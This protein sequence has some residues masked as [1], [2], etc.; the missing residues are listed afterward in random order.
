MNHS[1]G[2]RRRF[3]S[4]AGSAMIE[5]ALGWFIMTTVF[6]STFQY[7]YI[8][9]RYNT[10]LNAVNNG[11]HF[12]ALQNYDSA[13][14]TP[15]PA[16]IT[17]VQD[18]VAYGDPTGTSTTPLVQGLTPSHVTV[19]IGANGSGNTFTP[20]SV[21]VAIGGASNDYTINAVVA[22]FTLSGKPTVTYPFQGL[23]CPSGTGC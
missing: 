12:A 23:Y 16:F 9:Y 8:F 20:A 10:V 6:V 4:R 17:A 5:F 15:A 14:S 11:A 18:M 22:N 13:S 2:K 19:T 1:L 3:D 21:T 7:G